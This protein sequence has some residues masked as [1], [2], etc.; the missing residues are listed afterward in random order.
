M[1]LLGQPVSEREARKNREPEVL[2]SVATQGAVNHLSCTWHLSAAP[3]LHPKLTERETL[4][5]LYPLWVQ[6]IPSLHPHE[7]TLLDRGTPFP[8]ESVCPTLFWNKQPGLLQS[9]SFS[10]SLHC[11]RIPTLIH[12]IFFSLWFPRAFCFVSTLI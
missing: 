5:L 9:G 3:W 10:V 1:T 7:E 6:A 8:R 12:P 4:E 2:A 11:L